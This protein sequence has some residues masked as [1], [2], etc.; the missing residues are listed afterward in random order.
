MFLV[1]RFPLSFTLQNF[2]PSTHDSEFCSGDCRLSFSILE[3]SRSAL[4]KWGRRIQPGSKDACVMFEWQGSCHQE[5]LRVGTLLHR[6]ITYMTSRSPPGRRCL[7]WLFY[8]YLSLG[9]DRGVSMDMDQE[10]R[11]H[12][13]SNRYLKDSIAIWTGTNQFVI[14]TALQIAGRQ[15]IRTET[16]TVKFYVEKYSCVGF[17]PTICRVAMNVLWLLSRHL[18]ASSVT[19]PSLQCVCMSMY[20][21]EVGVQVSKRRYYWARMCCYAVYTERSG[22][23]SQSLIGDLTDFLY[24]LLLWL[25][26]WFLLLASVPVVQYRD[27]VRWTTNASASWLYLLYGKYGKRGFVFLAF[28][29]TSSFKRQNIMYWEKIRQ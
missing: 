9:V 27:F 16:G 2:I 8:Y 24:S 15:H 14:Q 29:A 1:N 20:T 12:F 23:C 19:Q 25:A 7:R 18:S 6:V 10:G 4:K 21:E 5:I 28:L 11:G 22:S 13:V 26:A 3:Q 17:G